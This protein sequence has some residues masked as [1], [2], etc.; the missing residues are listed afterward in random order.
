MHQQFVGDN[1]SSYAFFG[2]FVLFS[3]CF[4]QKLLASMSVI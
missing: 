4:L 2:L 1:V 3:F